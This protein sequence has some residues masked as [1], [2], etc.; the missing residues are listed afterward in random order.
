[1]SD[2]LKIFVLIV[3]AMV[4]GQVCYGVLVYALVLSGADRLIVAAAFWV[5]RV[6]GL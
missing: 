5:M 3:A 1:M 6:T 2:D 4:V